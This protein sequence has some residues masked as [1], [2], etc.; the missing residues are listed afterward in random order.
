M[1]LLLAVITGLLSWV[2]WDER[3]EV[4]YLPLALAAIWA[5]FTLGALAR[6]AKPE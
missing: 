1:V 3:N 2:G 4:G 5:L 6:M